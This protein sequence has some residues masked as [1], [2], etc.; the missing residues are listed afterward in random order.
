MKKTVKTNK[1]VFGAIIAAISAAALLTTTAFAAPITGMLT[2][3]TQKST[4][5]SSEKVNIQI[6]EKTNDN[7]TVSAV[8]TITSKTDAAFAQDS[9]NSFVLP[10][11]TDD[12]KAAD[13]SCT[14]SLADQI[15]SKLVYHPASG[16]G[17]VE[18]TLTDANTITAVVNY[19]DKE[20]SVSGQ[21]LKIKDDKLSVYHIDEVIYK[22]DEAMKIFIDHQ[23][24]EAFWADGL[25]I[26][27]KAEK[28]YGK[29][30]SAN[31]HAV[32]SPNGDVVIATEKVF[33]IDYTVSLE[34]D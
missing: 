10:T 3:G 16:D 26:F 15:E 12:G 5:I 7:N 23:E 28:A 18:Y 22:S 27:G 25:D 13:V 2:D 9:V 21:T 11:F 17:N 34:L 24:D 32:Y 33:D 19:N 14:R 4:S 20:F 8:M 31:Q 30:L 1:K 29:K 6:T